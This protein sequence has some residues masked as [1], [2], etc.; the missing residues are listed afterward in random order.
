MDF[1]TPPPDGDVSKG[2]IHIIIVVVLG[3][4][5]AITTVLRVGVRLANRQQGWDDFTIALATVLLLVQ[6][7]F[8]GLQYHEGAGRHAFY[9]GVEKTKEATKWSFAVMTLFFGI[10][11]LTKL[12][13][14]L[15]FLRTKTT[16]WIKWVIYTL[17]AGVVITAVV[18]EIILFVQCRPIST[19]WDRSKGTCTSQSVYNS[20][21][22]TQAGM[23]TLFALTYSMLIIHELM[24]SCR[25]SSAP[26]CQPQYS[27]MST[28]PFVSRHLCVVS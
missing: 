27:G 8:C 13:I 26:F 20:V 17:M 23:A 24:L 14:F 5:S 16:G 1:T 3:L 22:W 18:P 2:T 7:I 6:I 4:F 21:L 28:S 15:L 12:S 9:L 19:F 10:F 25:I 11:C